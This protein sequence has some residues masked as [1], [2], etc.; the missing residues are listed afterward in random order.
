MKNSIIFD[1]EFGASGDMILGALIDLGLDMKALL[2]ELGKIRLSGWAISPVRETKYALSGISAHVRCAEEHSERNLNEITAIITESGTKPEVKE[3]VLKIFGRLAE[4][5]AAVHGVDVDEIHFHEV[6][7]AD[8]IIDI[9]A[10]CIALQLLDIEKCYFTE[11][12]FGRGTVNSRHGE[13]PVPVPAVVQLARGFRSK[14]TGREGELITPTA[15]AILTAIGQQVQPPFGF[16]LLNVGI[17][18]GSR[19]YP[20][21]SYTRALL[22]QT[23]HTGAEE[24]Y[25][26]EF[27]IDDMNP[28][29]YP[30]L[31][32]LLFKKGAL[33]AYLT[34]IGMKKGRPGQLVTVI[35]NGESMDAIRE[36]VYTETTTLGVRIF[37]VI[38]EKLQREMKTIE[39][40]GKEV[41][42]K[43]GYI[44][45]RI[46]NAQPEFED[47]RKV[48]DTTGIP[49]KKVL[50]MAIS[51]IMKA[52]DLQEG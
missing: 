49:L 18:F 29:L 47:C 27:N 38:R 23:G 12:S 11:F 14:L 35:A 44:N 30:H 52:D 15:A 25:Q 33:D 8:S 31:I 19:K 41:R 42:I 5:E 48:S 6:G 26:L 16:T 2:A 39:I 34:P 28:Q 32:E 43:V 37:P 36:T 3:S 45:G 22:V 17:G 1:L 7:A 10:F 24:V 20:F 4:A 50:Q 40:E 13:L 21:P 51:E 46:I 9:A